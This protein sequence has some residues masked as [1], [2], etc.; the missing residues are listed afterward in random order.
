MAKYNVT[1]SCGHVERVDL[2]GPT[3][4]REWRMEHMKSEICWD[5]RQAE[6]RRQNRE[7]AKANRESELP[8]LTGTEKQVPW[9][10]SIRARILGEVSRVLESPDRDCKRL[11]EDMRFPA[12]LDALYSEARAWWWIDNRASGPYTLLTALLGQTAPPDSPVDHDAAI[13]AKA[14]ATVRPEKPKTETVAEIRVTGQN[15][16]VLF[17]EK[18]EDFRK[19]MHDLR[20]HWAEILW[21]RTIKPYLG[22]V[23]DRAA[24]VGHR[25]LAAGFSIRLFDPDLR[26]RAVNGTYAPEIRR[27]VRKRT[28]G[29]YTDWFVISWPKTEDY[30]QAAKRIR[31]SRYAKGGVHVPA[32]QFEQVLDFAELFR[33]SLSDGAQELVEQAKRVRDR[34]LVARVP[35]VQQ[36]ST[37]EVISRIPPKLDIPDEVT[38]DAA[39]CDDC[40]LSDDDAIA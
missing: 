5:C 6:M 9:A 4:S 27:W 10:E 33:F 34:A 8:A 31:G 15:I 20:Y 21:E 7:A 19:L 40:D 18:R 36:Q 3:R 28:E 39:L 37:A 35:E 1:H 11:R 26:E 38:I 29:P 12:A 2:I 32:E 17:P 30:Y 13:E 16:G 24:E 22:E 25:L 23:A 14:E